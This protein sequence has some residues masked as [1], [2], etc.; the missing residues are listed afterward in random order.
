MT[1]ILRT[2]IPGHA[3]LSPEDLL[4]ETARLGLDALML[5]SPLD[6]SP[7]LDPRELSALRGVAD[8]LGLAIGSGIGWFNPLRPE[9]MGIAAAL[10]GGDAL[11]GVR[12]IV[13]ALPALGVTEAFFQIGTLEDRFG[14]APP[15]RDHL[16]AAAEGLMGLSPLLR[17][18]GLRLLL[19]THE[20]ITTQEILRLI[21]RVGADVL[22]VA[23]DPVNVIVR[24]EDP[25]EATRRLA[26]HVRQ[27]HLEDAALHWDGP[28]LRRLMC[29]IGEGCLDWPAILATAPD[30]PVWAEL[31]RGQFA[32]PVD[33]AEWLASQPDIVP[34]EA[35]RVRAMAERFAGRPAPDQ[36]DPYAR[37]PRL[38]AFAKA[39]GKIR[40]G[41]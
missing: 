40:M 29:P 8:S 26:R 11:A 35:A 36:S 34:A 25:V 38:I 13:E 2:S 39:H 12:R 9:R 19:K 17:R 24:L 32:M 28:L 15:W 33:D 22:G 1:G 31:H 27:I 6:V 20:E 14:N 5:A 4:R 16:D 10:A 3:S 21:D 18:S 23:L 7:T 41:A 30:V 37:L